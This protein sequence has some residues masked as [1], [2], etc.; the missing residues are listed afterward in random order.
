VGIFVTA[1][2]VSGNFG[3]FDIFGG[4][5]AAMSYSPVT[6][7]PPALYYPD[8]RLDVNYDMAWLFTHEFQH[9][10]DL[11]MVP[12]SGLNMLHGHPYTDQNEPFFKGNYIGGEHWDW[13][14]CTFRNFNFDDWIRVKE[15][16]IQTCHSEK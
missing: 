1:P 12:R 8:T 6:P 13:I 7:S 10:I 14:A 16:S 4:S 15:L 3:G 9:A 2:D 11:I 5:A